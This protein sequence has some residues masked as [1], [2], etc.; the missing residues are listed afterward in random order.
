MRPAFPTRPGLLLALI[1]AQVACAVFYLA[2]VV[3][4]MRLAG[5]VSLDGHSAFELLAT[6]VLCLTLVFEY[7]L[8]LAY[9]RRAAHLER[10][11]SVAASAF[12]D[13]I[14]EQF[15]L[16]GLTPSER[17]VAQFLIKGCD[18]A[19]IAR[20]R[21]SAEGT[22]KSHLNAIY[23]KAGVSGRGALLSLLIDDLMDAPLLPRD[24]GAPVAED[25]GTEIAAGSARL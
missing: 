5:G 25:T 11:V 2:D 1:A 7:R 6:L 24:A 17:E 15:A 22:V 19:E 12:Q 23:R 18:I 20:L 16:W 3:E 21:S 13:V 14:A 9:R 4:D 8:L 10:Q